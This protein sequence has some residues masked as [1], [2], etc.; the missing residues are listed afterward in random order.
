[1]ARANRVRGNGSD[2]G[3]FHITHRCHNRQFL[4]KLACDRDTYRE[5]LR[6]HL[7]KFDVRLLD[8]CVTSNHVHL[9]MDAEDRLE[10]SRFMQEVAS[11][12]ARAYNRR[13]HRM[14]AYWGDNFHATLVESG[15]YLWECM[16]YVELNMNR[17][18]VVTHPR[19]WQWLGY[20]EIMGLR[21]RYR[22]IDLDRLCWRL[23]A[24]SLEDI[25]KHL[26]A[27]LSERIA[28]DQVKREPRWTESL[29]VGS[30]GFVEKIKP[31][32]LSRRET[33]MVETAEN[34]W[35]LREAETP[36]GQKTGRESGVKTVF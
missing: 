21:R 22:L 35:A 17:C 33:E 28:G 29:A 16:C 12:F 9:L 5:K 10:V 26:E 30:A 7:K 18:G 23:G 2:G 14:N 24:S 27:S 13:K 19:E 11:E 1:M 4:L 8:Y 20:H 3:I 32:I 25:R 31:L 15:R 34:M 36:Y 6:E